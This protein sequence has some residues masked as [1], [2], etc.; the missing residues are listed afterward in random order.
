MEQLSPEERIERL[1]KTVLPLVEFSGEQ[2]E[3]GKKINRELK[4]RGFSKGEESAIVRK[5]LMRLIEKLGYG[6]DGEFAEFVSYYSQVEDVKL[7][8][9]SEEMR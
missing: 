8:A 3:K 9:E 6:N 7:M 5:A 1:E 4:D 2:T